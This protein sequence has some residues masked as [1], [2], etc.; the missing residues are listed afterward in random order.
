M[1][2]P[3]RVQWEGAWYHVTSRGQERGAIFWD[4][5]DRRRFLENHI[6]FTAESAGARSSWECE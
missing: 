6:V 5:E 3:L 2:R 1:A 4:D